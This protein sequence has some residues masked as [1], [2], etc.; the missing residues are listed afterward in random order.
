MPDS[1]M[2]SAGLSYCLGCSRALAADAAMDAAPESSSREDKVR[3]RRTALIG[4]EIGR[5][6][7]QPDRVI[8]NSCRTSSQA[9]AAVRAELDP[10]PS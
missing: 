1:W 8:A 6:P 3:L 5:R 10:R 9:V 7:G 4:F 2:N